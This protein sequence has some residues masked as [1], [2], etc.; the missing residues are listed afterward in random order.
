MMMLHT[1]AP[2]GTH[3][4]IDAQRPASHK[5]PSTTQLRLQSAP[6]DCYCLIP[7]AFSLHLLSYQLLP[8]A[9]TAR[10]QRVTK[11]LEG[12]SGDHPVEP[13]C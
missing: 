6:Q 7:L 2:T 5:T 3:T 13:P 4:M 11:G 1:T 8:R 12:T 9:N 10:M